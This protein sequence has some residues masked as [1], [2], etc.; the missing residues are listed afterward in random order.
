MKGIF[1]IVYIIEVI[2]QI[3]SIKKF[4]KFRD[5][6]YWN[7]FFGITIANFISI[8]LAF[9]VFMNNE[10]LSRNDIITW[11]FI[12]GVLFIANLILLIK[13]NINKNSLENIINTNEKSFS[14]GFLCVFLSLMILWIVPSFIISE[15]AITNNSISYLN[16]KYGDHDFK[17]SSISKDYSQ[18]GIIQKNRAGYNVTVFSPI[19]KSIFTLSISSNN[20]LV[21]NG[22]S[23]E[24]VE[25]YY[26]MNINEYLSKKYGL[27]IEFSIEEDNIPNSV[28]HI[29]TIN[30]LLDYNAITYISI[31]ADKNSDYD[32][33]DN[34]NGRINYLR[35]L[36]IDLIDYL[37]ISKNINIKFS[38]S[39]GKDS[40]N[41]HIN[42]A[43]G[44]IKIID[45]DNIMYEYKIED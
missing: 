34:L 5:N 8:F 1:F 30:E 37:N 4:K 22:V 18:N 26:Q 40:Y 20:S 29:P 11:L 28:G 12:F 15:S 31:I 3:E 25:M 14:T 13:G 17:V 43:N 24:F 41:C 44:K 21:M 16:N 2:I 39:L 36:S 23:E 32:Y 6:K 35:E 10:G 45:Y 42:I 27:K 33:D 7:E 38:R 19:L 9:F